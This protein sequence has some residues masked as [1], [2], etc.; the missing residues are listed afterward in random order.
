[1][2]LSFLFFE[3]QIF[4]NGA[5]GP[6]SLLST[7]FNY[8]QQWAID[9]I[10]QRITSS[11]TWLGVAGSPNHHLHWIDP[12]NSMNQSKQHYFEQKQKKI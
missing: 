7:K 3:T 6:I 10:V 5:P 2:Y 1:M 9:T 12:V 8:K 11:F 4:I